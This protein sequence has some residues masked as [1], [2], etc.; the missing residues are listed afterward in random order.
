MATAHANTATDH[1]TD[2]AAYYVPHGS[3]WPV[4][5]SVAGWA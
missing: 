4:Y 2:A 1:G 5:A 3:R